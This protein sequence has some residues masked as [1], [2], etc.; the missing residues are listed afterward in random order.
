VQALNIPCANSKGSGAENSPFVP[1]FLIC[2]SCRTL[3]NVND[4]TNRSCV[5]TNTTQNS[6]ENNKRR[7][8][9]GKTQSRR[10][11]RRLQSDRRRPESL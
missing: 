3:T 10:S 11:T 8:S 9:S 5:T 2:Q 6:S 4:P 7:R 1:S